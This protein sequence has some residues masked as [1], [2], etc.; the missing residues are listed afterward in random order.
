MTNMD[1]QQARE[2]ALRLASWFLSD[3]TSRKNDD[4]LELAE[5]FRRF[6]VPRGN[7]SVERRE[8]ALYQAIK[9]DISNNDVIETAKE[10]YEFIA[11][12]GDLTKR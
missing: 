8:K 2:P 10:Y 3:A 7:E 5:E 9:N 4:V 11:S 6:L 1:P 12:G